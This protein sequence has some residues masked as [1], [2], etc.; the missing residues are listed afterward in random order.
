MTAFVPDYRHV[1]DAALNRRPRRL[2]FYE[3]I[4][5]V[6]TMEA[7]AGRAFGSLLGGDAADR[8][9]FFRQF[10][11]FFR[12]HGYDTVSF[13]VCVT[14]ILPGGGALMAER[15]GV[16]RSRADLDAYP[17]D[18]L[19]RLFWETAEPRLDALA[20][21]LPPGMKAVGGVGNG[22]FEIS[23]DLAGFADLCYLEADDPEAFAELYRRIGDLLAALW[24]RLVARHGDLFC[25][26][27]TGDDM[28][29]KSQ[30]LL[31]PATLLAH[32]VPQYRRL[33]G[34]VHAAGRPYLLHS[35]GCIFD[36]M[37]PLIATGIDAK[38]SNEDVIAP[39]DAWIERYGGRIGLFGGIDT[40]RLCRMTPDAV[41]AF[42]LEEAARFRRMARGYALGSGNSIPGYVP[43]EGYL[44]MLRAGEEL[45]RRESPA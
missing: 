45:R 1:V 29:F 18:D 8:R 16:I 33:A 10:A 17:W 2:P 23:E 12:D 37:E 44:A 5:G 25:V 22:V 20:A 38:H 15:P 3:H 19:P 7:I 14:E 39:F 21:V 30:T 43:P 41:H 31:A 34:I 35:C 26:C 28:G 6:D 32:V 11:G 9:E 36:I 13:E 40:D 27:R 4:V 42:V 24:R